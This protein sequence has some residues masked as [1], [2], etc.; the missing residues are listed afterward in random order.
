MRRKTSG[1]FVFSGI[2]IGMKNQVKNINEEIET[3]RN[4]RKSF[5]KFY[6]S[7]LKFK[8]HYFEIGPDDEATAKERGE[9]EQAR[10]KLSGILIDIYRSSDNNEEFNEELIELIEFTGSTPEEISHLILGLHDISD[11]DELKTIAK[12]LKHLAEN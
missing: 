11:A 10:K 2:I 7:F 12:K 3:N 4:L 5:K 8:K 6:E 1:I 9:L